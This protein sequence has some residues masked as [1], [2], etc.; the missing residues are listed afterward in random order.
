LSYGIDNLKCQDLEQDAA[1]G[2]EKGDK[3]KPNVKNVSGFHFDNTLFKHTNN[4]I[5]V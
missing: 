4:L 2:E 3:K 1:E 5:K